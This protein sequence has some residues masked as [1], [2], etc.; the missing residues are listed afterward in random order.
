M[1]QN[2]NKFLEFN[3]KNLLFLS[4]EGVYYIAI[5]PICQAIEVDYVQQYK[6]VSDD[7]ILGPVLCKH[8]MQVP[9]DQA[10]QMVCLPEQYIYGWLFSIRSESK[11]L[12]EYKRRCYNILYDHFHGTITKRRNLIIDKVNTQNERAKLELKLRESEDFNKWEELKA[13]EAR[14]GKSMKDVDSEEISL[15]LSIFE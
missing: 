2:I 1:K 7:P 8:T 12:I 15:Q 6:N 11:E 4:K 14:I 10:R 5:K 13:R 9:G 3:G